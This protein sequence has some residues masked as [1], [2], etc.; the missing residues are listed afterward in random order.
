M[1]EIPK[2]VIAVDVACGN[3]GMGN[4]TDMY[5]ETVTALSNYYMEANHAVNIVT[6]RSNKN[7]NPIN[8]YYD[9]IN[10]L[11][12][13]MY[14]M[15]S[16]PFFTDKAPLDV[17]RF[18]DKEFALADKIFIITANPSASMFSA[19][20]DASRQGKSVVCV[21]PL[22]G[23]N[24]PA[25]LQKAIEEAPIGPVIIRSVDE[26]SEKVGPAL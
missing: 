1:P 20:E 7:I 5:V 16:I 12:L 10:D 25:L 9:D 17:F 14:D 15:I 8:V 13:L 11:G 6:V 2:I 19:M 26:I 3:D 24:P 18:T 23:E 21:M 22:W 4:I